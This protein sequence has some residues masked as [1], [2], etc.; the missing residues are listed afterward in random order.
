MDWKSLIGTDWTTLIDWLSNDIDNSSKALLTDWDSNWS[1][2]ISNSLSSDETFGGIKGNSTHIVSSKM[3]SNLKDKSVLG[4]LDFESVE[5][6]WEFSS[7]LHIDDGTNN[8][9]NLST[10]SAESSYLD[11]AEWL[12]CDSREG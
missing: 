11:K 10:G 9:R 1:S 5:N 4:S 7:E 12:L 2:S 8:L 3:L 6:W